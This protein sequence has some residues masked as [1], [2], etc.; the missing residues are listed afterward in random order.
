MRGA[1]V[2]RGEP[3]RGFVDAGFRIGASG[4]AVCHLPH[5]FGIE[6]NRPAI[7]GGSASS[8][9]LRGHGIAPGP[10]NSMSGY[11]SIRHARAPDSAAAATRP[12]MG[13]AAVGGRQTRNSRYWR[14]QELMT[15]R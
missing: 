3:P 1:V 13:E 4:S 8:V 12:S 2:D 9:G 14:S 5:E 15:R 6:L 11:H 10:F 7:P